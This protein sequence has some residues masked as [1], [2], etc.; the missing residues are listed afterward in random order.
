MGK[1]TTQLNTITALFMLTITQLSAQERRIDYVNSFSGTKNMGHTF[2]G[3]CVP[4]G[5]GIE[6][7]AHYPHITRLL[8]D[9]LSKPIDC[10]HNLFVNRIFYYSNRSKVLTI[11][12]CLIF[13]RVQDHHL[14]KPSIILTIIALLPHFI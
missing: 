12:F 10:I 1:M 9:F 6:I 5:T 7:F 4:V 14:R 8:T 2:P 13:L 11:Y 3:A